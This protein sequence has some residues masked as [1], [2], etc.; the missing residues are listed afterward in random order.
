MHLRVW[1][2]H[3][4]LSL[5]ACL[6]LSTFVCLLAGQLLVEHL[7]LLHAYRYDK[8]APHLQP[9]TTKTCKPSTLKALTP[10]LFIHMTR[11]EACIVS[12]SE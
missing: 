1:W 7:A 10:N 9:Q 12:S 8:L 2:L 6:P 3:L 4:S 5:S 11:N